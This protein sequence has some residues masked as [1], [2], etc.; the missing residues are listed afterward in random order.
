[1]ILH[2]SKTIRGIYN[3]TTYG[4]IFCLILS[5]IVFNAPK[6]SKASYSD[7]NFIADSVYNNSGTMNAADINN[8]LKVHGSGYAD[9]VIADG[10]NVPYPV[11]YHTYNYTWVTQDSWVGGKQIAIFA[12]RTVAQLIY[13]ESREHSINPQLILAML[14]KESSSVTQDAKG[15]PRDYWA[16]GYGYPDGA[17]NCY[18]NGTSCD[19]ARYK[20]NAEALAG[21]G[22]QIAFATAFLRSKFDAE[23]NLAD[24][25]FIDNQ[26]I[27]PQTTA[28]R[29]L[30][31]W[32]TPHLTW[33]NF[34]NIFAGWF[35]DPT[36]TPPVVT[37][38][39]ITEFNTSTYSDSITLSGSKAGDNQ[40]YYNGQLIASG[41]GGWEFSIPLEYGQH[42]YVVMYKNNGANV[43]QKNININR[44]KTGDINGDGTI[45]IQDLSILSNNWGRSQDFTDSM[46]NL[47]PDSDNVVDIL[48]LSILASHWEG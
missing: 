32:Y 19:S 20:A 22:C 3:F 44:H 23:K 38:N 18:A 24:P 11:S 30:Y 39:D 36:Y 31:K 21:V 27:Y 7:V 12:G 47:N 6:L 42:T 2:G 48:D 33:Q 9:Y 34:Y 1:M 26:Y 10:Y 41:G 8:F 43:A 28:T 25:L 37:Y 15:E 29:T 40:V 46:V 4:V 16:M 5:S 45:N 14:Q 35:G 13:D 17:S